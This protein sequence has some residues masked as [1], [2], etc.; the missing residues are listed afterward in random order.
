VKS[1]DQWRITLAGAG[2]V[3]FHLGKALVQKGYVISRVL[4]RTASFSEHL[5]EELNA[6]SSGIPED[7]VADSDACL[8]CVSDDAIATVIEKL[9][10]GNCLMMHTAGSVPMDVFR[11]YAINYGVLYPLQTFTK[12]R[13][14]DYSRI[15]F[16]VEANTTENL[17]LIHQ[18]A[19]SVSVITREADSVQRLYIHLAAIFASNFSNHMYELSEMLAGEHHMSFDLLKPLIEETTAKAMEISPKKAQTG[20]AVRGNTKVI[21]KHLELLKDHPRMQDLYRMITEDIRGL[22]T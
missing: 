21:E 1:A 17:K 9:K 7:G 11:D 8:V 18:I 14:L 3:A 20:P 13:P 16:L 22:G 6:E 5:A 2:N 12:N 15:P 10:P 4:D 19:S